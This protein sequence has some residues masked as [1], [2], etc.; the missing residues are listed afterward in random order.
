MRLSKVA[1]IVH[2]IKK[3]VLLRERFTPHIGVENL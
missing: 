1:T 2:N 3:F